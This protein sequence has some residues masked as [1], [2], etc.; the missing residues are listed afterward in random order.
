M[1]DERLPYPHDVVMITVNE[2]KRLLRIEERMS[3]LVAAITDDIRKTGDCWHVYQQ[4][5]RL[6]TGTMGIE[7][8]ENDE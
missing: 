6:L 4:S 5:L 2:Y 3:L 8:E 1:C 7:K